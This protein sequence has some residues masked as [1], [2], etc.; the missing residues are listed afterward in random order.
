M[1]VGDYARTKTGIHKIF[2][3]DENKTVWKYQCDKKETGEWDSSYEYIQIKD[4]DIIKSSPNI[5]DLLEP[6]DLLYVDI[7]NGYEDGIIV[8]RIAETQNEL[9][10]YITKI[11]NGTWI[12]SGVMTTEQLSRGAYWL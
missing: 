3:I 4:E 10:E 12:L 7:D 8:P 1:K 6:M 11:K 5:I 2:K 9:D